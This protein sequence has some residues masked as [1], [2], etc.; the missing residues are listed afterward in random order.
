M[1]YQHGKARISVKGSF[2][3]N[4]VNNLEFS[5]LYQGKMSQAPDF[6]AVL[7]LLRNLPERFE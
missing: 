4:R 5:R 6:K 1:N 3:S 7:G 2:S